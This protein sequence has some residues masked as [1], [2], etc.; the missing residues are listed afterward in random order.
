MSMKQILQKEKVK[1]PNSET[2]KYS[3][4]SKIN[5]KNYK[6]TYSFFVYD[7]YCSAIALRRNRYE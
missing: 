5:S 3:T 6:L 2:L 4:M 7:K 1:I